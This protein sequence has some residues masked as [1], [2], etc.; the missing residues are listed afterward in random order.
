MLQDFEK[1]TPLQHEMRRAIVIFTHKCC[2]L[3]GKRFCIISQD[4]KFGRKTTERWQVCTLPTNQGDKIRVC[5][6]RLF[7]EIETL[8]EPHDHV[9]IFINPGFLFSP[10]WFLHA[11]RKP[12]LL[13]DRHRDL[14]LMASP[15]EAREQCLEN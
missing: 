8:K 1:V 6:Y 9:L 5:I 11:V 10:C 14:Q 7:K 15:H 13:L 4:E 2:W 12:R 3:N